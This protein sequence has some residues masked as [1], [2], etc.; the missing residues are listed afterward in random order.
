MKKYLLMA[1]ALL[2]G[3][4]CMTSCGDDK[5][6]IDNITNGNGLGIGQ[7]NIEDKG[8]IIVH[9]IVSQIYT[10]TT[11]YTFD[12][13]S[14]SSHLIKAVASVAFTN[15][16]SAEIYWDEAMSIIDEDDSLSPQEKQAEKA[17]MKK[18]GNTIITDV[19]D[20]FITEDEDGELFTPT[21]AYILTALSYVK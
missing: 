13:N 8:N 12:G 1:V 18:N 4:M 3:A 16:K 17:K 20:N 19:T 10:T 7:S 15:S 21:K 6:E 2:M 5:D 14:E 11:T 9:T